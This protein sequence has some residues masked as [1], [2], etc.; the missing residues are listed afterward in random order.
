VRAIVL[1][2]GEGTRL[3]PLTLT[4]PK[5][6]LPVAEVA[7]IERVLHHLA[8]HGVDEAVL[9]MGYRPDAFVVAFPE[10]R[11]AGVRLRYAV[12]PEPLDTAGAIRFAAEEAGLEE[13]FLVVNGDVLTDM[14]VGA[15]VAFHE[16]R[17]AVGT[18]SL[19]PVEDPSAFGVVPVDAE[20]RV[21]AFIEKPP[22]DAAPTNLINAGTYVL[23]P[24]MLQLIPA[25]RRVS[26][27]REVFPQLAA[28][29]SLFAL[30]SDAYW[31]D[32]GTP[33]DY[34]QANADVLAGRRGCEVAPGA[35]EREPGVWV[36]GG[37]VIDGEVTAPSLVGD[38]AFI[39]ADAHV[40][41]SVVGG[42]AR[43]GRG[44]AV[45]GSVVLPGAVVGPDA[46][47]DRS[48][49]GE[50]AAVHEG[51]RVEAVSVVGGGAVVASGSVLEG[52]RVAA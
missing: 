29:G 26:V 38:A 2:G 16:A 28:Q 48:I 41:G 8:G 44:A 25:G 30:A 9:S 17:G 7:M 47:V 20:G 32:T 19:T 43:V 40:S 23:E 46:V 1:V 22:R 3:R 5:P 37:P 51:A 15:L 21:Q 11:A 6:L 31:L 4:T 12:E 42:G 14:D 39:A 10:D 18:V 50:A 34:L 49:I 24:D 36:I 33:E 27:E 45:R 35:V 13:R 52:A